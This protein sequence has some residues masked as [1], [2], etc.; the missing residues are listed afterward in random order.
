MGWVSFLGYLKLFLY[1]HIKKQMDKF[2]DGIQ[3]KYPWRD[4]QQRVL[5]Q[6]ET[7]LSNKHLHVVAPPGSGKTVLGL[8]VAIRINKPTLILAPTLAIKN[9]WIHRLCELFLNTSEVPEWISRDIRNPSFLTVVTY[10]GL[11]TACRDLSPEIAENEEEEEMELIDHQEES[12]SAENASFLDEIV[13]GLKEAGIKTIVVDEAHHLKNEWWRTLT[14][15][16]ERL[17]PKIIGLT[18]TPPFDVGP[19]EWRRYIELNGP[20]DAEIAVPELILAGD[21]CPHQD[22]VNLS[23]PTVMETLVLNDFRKNANAVFESLNNDHSLIEAFKNHPLWTDPYEYLEWIYENFEYYISI[24]R[25][26]KYNGQEV[27]K[28]HKKIIVDGKQ[29]NSGFDFESMELLLDYF[30]YKDNT[31]FN[32]YSER[33]NQIRTQLRRAGMLERRRINFREN[34]S[35]VQLLTGSIAKLD[36]ISQ[37]TH[38]EY[39]QK[40]I[41]LRLVILTDYIR[42]EFLVSSDSNELELNK[43][44]AIPI[45]EHLRRQNEKGIKLGVLTGSVVIIPATALSELNLKCK[46]LGLEELNSNPLAFDNDYVLLTLNN[47]HRSKIVH[48]ITYIFQRGQ[49]EVLIGTKALL[50]QGWDAPAINS[51]ILASFVG[52]FVLSNQMRGRAIRVNP[53]ELNKTANIWHLA[54]VDPTVDNGGRDL[55]MLRRRFRS[56]VGLSYDASP[57]IQNG[58][59]R[60]EIPREIISRMEVDEINQDIFQYASERDQLKARW[61]IALKKGIQLVEE[62]KVPYKGN[63]D[64]TSAKR[65]HFFKTLKFLFANLVILLIITFSYTMEYITHLSRFHH[66]IQ[67]IIPYVIFPLLF[68]LIT[69]AYPSYRY[70]RLYLNHRDLTKD[71]DKITKS[72]L[73]SLIEIG[74]V[75][76]RPSQIA[77]KTSIDQ[78]GSISCH[79]EGTSKHEQSVFITALMEVAEKIDNPRYLIIRQSVLHGLFQQKDYHAVPTIFGRNK[80]LAEVF[81]KNWRKYVG[82]CKLVFSRT[83]EGR[84]AL[85][86]ARVKSLTSKIDKMIEQEEKWM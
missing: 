42:R 77:I 7:Y 65:F 53:N 61:D 23:L 49:I 33:K 21:L 44:G 57:I 66:Q 69:L 73:Y 80:Q 67:D 58:F 83:P 10:Q 62:I 51:L 1:C 68:I 40:G 47:S 35:V 15:V 84:R 85:L 50:G 41:S 64:F 60:L 54:T 8:E 56:F 25:F 74:E 59:G 79:M 12:N 19:N 82:S 17:S 48:L 52:S 32:E 37:I 4:Y 22:F 63:E 16:K 18:A 2:P 70:L 55:E 81:E 71:F 11:H 13:N 86:N 36:S 24:L 29:L 27:S 39:G 34:N 3:F 43:I 20:V 75:K 28:D 78:F 38:F 6:L 26:L 5:D 31:H 72:L 30:L 9:Q 76:T 45:F 14:S 46:K